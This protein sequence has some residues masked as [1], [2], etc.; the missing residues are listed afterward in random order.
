MKNKVYK[1]KRILKIKLIIEK[2]LDDDI[3][4]NGE[5]NSRPLTR[6]MEIVNQGLE[7][8]QDKIC[9]GSEMSGILRKLKE[10]FIVERKSHSIPIGDDP[11]DRSK[12]SRVYY[13]ID[14]K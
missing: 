1:E 4:E 13:F 8:T 7:G 6:W 12:K 5:A 10:Y 11:D 14:K 9:N 3:R 2:E